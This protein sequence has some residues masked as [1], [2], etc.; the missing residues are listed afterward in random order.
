[1]ILDVLDGGFLTTVQD[2][3]RPDWTHLGVP[4]SG[5]SDPWSLAV[6]NLLAGNDAEAAALEITLLGP[7]LRARDD[8]LVAL[9][10]ADLGGRIDGGR[11]LLPGRGHRIS[12]GETIR[13]EPGDGRGDG[14]RT[15]LALPGGVDVPP[16]LGSRSTC[17]AG[18]FGGLEGRSLRAGDVLAAADR[19]RPTDRPEL[20]WPE[21]DDSPPPDDRAPATLRLLPGPMPHAF[22]ALVAGDWRVAAAADRVGMR[23]E[24]GATL[25]A[26]VGGETVTHGVPWGA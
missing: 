16:V 24:G 7:T 15:Y 18:G 11:R 21:S 12:A 5:A 1:M 9:A 6:A 2:A 3:G 26:G 23:L 25:A 17:L 4:V 8:G 22:D 20:A 14:A 19:G 10:G 13:F